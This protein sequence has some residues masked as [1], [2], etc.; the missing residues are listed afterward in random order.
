MR[1]AAARRRGPASPCVAVLWVAAL[2]C[3]SGAKAFPAPNATVPPPSPFATDLRALAET[4]WRAARGEPGGDSGGEEAPAAAL[5]EAAHSRV[6]AGAWAGAE[7][8]LAEALS[9]DGQNA[10]ARYLAALVD[11][12]LRDDVRAALAELDAALASGR[13]FSYERADAE[14]LRARLFNRLRQ[15]ERALASLA[16]L[17]APA[18]AALS[19]RESRAAGA[20]Y[21]RACA[22]RTLGRRDEMLSVLE[23]SAR[24]FPDDARFA[25][26]FF[27][28]LGP[29]P[30]STAERRLAAVFMDRF[31][32]RKGGGGLLAADPELRILALP[33]M[34][35]ESDRR[36]ALLAYRATGF[37]SPLA[38]LAA[39]EYGLIPAAA[40]I[41]EFFGAAARIDERLMRQLPTLLGSAEDFDAFA[42]CL[43]LFSGT[44]VGDRDA[45]GYPERVAVYERGRLT[46]FR[47]D[48]DQDGRFELELSCED[49]LPAGGRL[50]R[51]GQIL[52]L[53]YGLYPY[54]ERLAFMRGD[55]APEALVLGATGNVAV[56]SSRTEFRFAPGALPCALVHFEPFPSRS[57]DALYLA[58]PAPISAPTE[59]LALSHAYVFT[60]QREDIEEEFRLE[61]GLAVAGE[62]RK[63]GRLYSVIA[64]ERGVAVLERIDEDGDGRYETE[65]G[66][67]PAAGP[68]AATLDALLWAR[69]DADGD[70]IFEYRESFRPPFRKE[71]DLNAD[72]VPDVASYREEGNLQVREFSTR[73]DGRFDQTLKVGPDGKIRATSRAGRDLPLHADSHPR[74]FWI[75]EKPFDLGG[76]LPP[77]SGVYRHMNR[78]Y[79]LVYFGDE[80]FAEL[81]P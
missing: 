43:R 12:A 11:L 55:T 66:L 7:E 78:R 30:F 27:E 36:D 24:L 26:L 46:A 38:T 69:R 49:G 13:F 1:R 28:T 19:L 25:R 77:R 68:E 22:L 42:A 74:L 56:T 37:R 50:S 44:L 39:L 76:N 59:A 52:E 63:D 45:D 73:L 18:P 70:G 34:L 10:D 51:E 6:R 57:V 65:R 5:V 64:F 71:W 41:N 75:G 9:L 40:A 14:L 61:G 58:V 79:M 81:L 2:G 62:R 21:E 3:L 20:L 48:D 8:L 54:L 16:F 15:P 72:G 17:D 4:A 80:A 32:D 29:S 67:D 33:A 35:G 47:L 60:R 53:R 31:V 23:R